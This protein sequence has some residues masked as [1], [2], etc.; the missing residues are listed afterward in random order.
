[1]CKTKSINNL[2]FSSLLNC[3]TALKVKKIYQ[4][5]TKKKNRYLIYNYLA[6]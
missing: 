1:M 4:N 3:S 5:T 6:Y 2:T